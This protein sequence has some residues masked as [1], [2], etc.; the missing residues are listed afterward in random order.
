MLKK[1]EKKQDRKQELVKIFE[2]VSKDKRDLV[3]PLIEDAVF[4]EEKLKDLKASCLYKKTAGG[5]VI[6][7][8]SLKVYKEIN[9]QY[10]QTIKT[11]GSFLKNQDSEAD[12]PLTEYLKKLN[13]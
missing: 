13:E 7:L 8:Q 6:A 3:L 11:L 4:L 5:N 10:L 9:N 12:S 1:Q 2:S